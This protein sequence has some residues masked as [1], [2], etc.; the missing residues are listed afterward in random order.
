MLLEGN[1]EH[2]DHAKSVQSAVRG[3]EDGTHLAA[4]QGRKITSRSSP[5]VVAYGGKPSSMTTSG[6]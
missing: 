1:S 2:D 6:T 5:G 4:T 3:R